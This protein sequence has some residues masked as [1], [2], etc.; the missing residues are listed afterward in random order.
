MKARFQGGPL[1]RQIR[2][3]DQPMFEVHRPVKQDVRA[4]L[5]ADDNLY[6]EVKKQTGRYYKVPEFDN[7]GNVI[8]AWAGWK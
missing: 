8:F 6:P 1:H 7:N 4:W 2:L 5:L 3:V